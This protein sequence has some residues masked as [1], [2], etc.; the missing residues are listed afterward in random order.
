MKLLSALKAALMLL[1]GCGDSTYT[2]Y[3]SSSTTG[4]ESWRLHIAT[5]DAKEDE[6]YNMGNCQIAQE[7]FQKQPGISV[8]YWCEKGNFKK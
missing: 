4:G 1:T 3:R 2:L 6:A 7:L 8:R 5:F